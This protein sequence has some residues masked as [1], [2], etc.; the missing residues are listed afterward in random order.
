M[1]SL[2]GHELLL[3]PPSRKEPMDLKPFGSPVRSAASGRLPAGWDPDMNLLEAEVE[4]RRGE[5]AGSG[6]DDL[7]VESSQKGSIVREERQ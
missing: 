4:R 7:D 3:C 1:L 6:D 5:G 2:S